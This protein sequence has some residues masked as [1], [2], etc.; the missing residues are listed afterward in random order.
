MDGTMKETG[1]L[2]NEQLLSLNKKQPREY[3]P[4]LTDLLCISPHCIDLYI[5]P[6]YN[7]FVMLFTN[8]YAALRGKTAVFRY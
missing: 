4:R 7:N 6:Y 2:T 1:E 3:H 5:C 8:K